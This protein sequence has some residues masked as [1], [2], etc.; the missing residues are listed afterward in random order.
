MAGCSA[1]SR[2]LDMVRAANSP[3]WGLNSLGKRSSAEPQ[4]TH[5]RRL[6][7]PGQDRRSRTRRGLPPVGGACAS[8]R[9]ATRAFLAH[10]TRAQPP[11]HPGSADIVLLVVGELVA[12]AIG[13]PTDP[14]TLRLALH[15]DHMDIAVAGTSPDPGLSL[16]RWAVDEVAERLA[17]LFLP[18]VADVVVLGD[19]WRNHR[20]GCYKALNSFGAGLWAA[21]K[22]G[23]R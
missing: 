1:P 6:P 5:R 21:K 22:P 13:T 19:V 12:N 16:A 10:A 9:E 3:E 4:S 23:H 17:D 14:C 15:G 11:T 2:C 18:S 7:R 8:A 20:G